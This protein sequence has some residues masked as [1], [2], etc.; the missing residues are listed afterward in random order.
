M[1]RLKKIEELEERIALLIREHDRR[2]QEAEAHLAL[3]Q[4]TAKELRATAE[5]LKTTRAVLSE[6]EAERVA[7]LAVLAAERK[8]AEHERA[9]AGNVKMRVEAR[10]RLILQ[11]VSKYVGEGADIFNQWNIDGKGESEREDGDENATATGGDSPPAP[12]SGGGSMANGS[13]KEAGER[14]V[15]PRT[16]APAAREVDS[17]SGFMALIAK[18]GVP[19]EP[20][21]GL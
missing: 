8:A 13:D 1:T 3:S 6:K 12:D 14:P 5:E 21:S 7:L 11:D 19:K 10:L 2:K 4:A 16:D 18:V 15:L 17:F 9:R 20:F